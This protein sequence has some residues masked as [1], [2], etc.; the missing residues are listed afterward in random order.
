M[1]DNLIDNDIFFDDFP[2]WEDAHSDSSNVDAIINGIEDVLE[3]SITSLVQRTEPLL[4]S[5]AIFPPLPPPTISPERPK[6]PKSP[7]ILFTFSNTTTPVF[8]PSTPPTDAKAKKA[9][10]TLLP[11]PPQQDSPI[12]PRT[13]RSSYAKKLSFKRPSEDKPEGKDAEKDAEE[14]EKDD[15]DYSPPS[16]RPKLSYKTLTTTPS[17]EA[18]FP[19]IRKPIPNKGNP[20][21]QN[22]MTPSSSS[23]ACLLPQRKTRFSKVIPPNMTSYRTIP[24]TDIVDP[25]PHLEQNHEVIV[26]VTTCLR[27]TIDSKILPFLSLK[28]NS[29]R[30]L[31]N[32]HILLHPPTIQK[33]IAQAKT[34]ALCQNIRY[35]VPKNDVPN[36]MIPSISYITS[37]GHPVIIPCNKHG[38]PQLRLLEPHFKSF[39]PSTLSMEVIFELK[40]P[41]S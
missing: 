39:N 23:G 40:R 27:T 24:N 12:R 11:T 33:L 5:P 3:V 29:F 21:L 34:F 32:I 17:K 41:S 18:T 35:M 2:Q 22:L 25:Y 10:R 31:S 20:S 28:L 37:T 15:H 1:D 36:Y 6:P 19:Y 4:P 9:K 16:K 26:D 8:P 30:F 38:Y 13:T 7:P 14:T